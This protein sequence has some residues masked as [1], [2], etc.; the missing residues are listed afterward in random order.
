[1]IDENGAHFPA[2]PFIA[3]ISHYFA[4]SK[5]SKLDF[6]PKN[7]S[8]VPMMRAGNHKK[9]QEDLE[10]LNTAAQAGL[11]NDTPPTIASAIH[12]K[13]IPAKATSSKN[14]VKVAPVMNAGV[15]ASA[16]T[17]P[18]VQRPAPVARHGKEVERI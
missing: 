9:I 5:L 13:V 6:T 12:Q 14:S 3:V 15:S 4:P 16:G 10:K 11:G 1:M 18:V 8:N 7:V 17:A 2:D